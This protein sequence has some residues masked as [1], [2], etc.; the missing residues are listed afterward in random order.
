MIYQVS[1]LSLSTCGGGHFFG[2]AMSKRPGVTES[3]ISGKNHKRCTMADS[4]TLMTTGTRGL[5][6]LADDSQGRNR[7]VD[8][9][10]LKTRIDPEGVHIVA[11]HMIHNDC[12]YRT[13]WMVKMKDSMD[14][15]NVW[16]DSSFDVFNTNTQ[17][18]QMN[19]IH[20]RELCY[21]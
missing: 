5:M 3:P 11:F 4:E 6:R 8:T 21:S 9:E 14:P 13:L 7:S 10:K 17:I 18:L 1:P 19:E 16:I 2:K 12:E 20:G 15:A